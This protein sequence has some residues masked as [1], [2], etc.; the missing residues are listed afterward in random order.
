MT[1]KNPLSN[2][3][4]KSYLLNLISSHIFAQWQRG[5]LGSV[6]QAEGAVWSVGA[7]GR[8][9]H[10]TYLDLRR[11][12]LQHQADDRQWLFVRCVTRHFRS[13]RAPLPQETHHEV[14]NLHFRWRHQGSCQKLSVVLLEKLY[15]FSCV[16]CLFLV[17]FIRK[18]SMATLCSTRAASTW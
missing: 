9:L 8:H 5:F 7:T 11:V 18:T 16:S 12:E 3:P 6:A 15:V 13:V 14:L 1:S 10:R 4:Q 17:L 2:I